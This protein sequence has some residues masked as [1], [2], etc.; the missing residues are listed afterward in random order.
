M[1]GV[2]ELPMNLFARIE[3]TIDA[4][5]IK[6]IQ[7]G[8]IKYVSSLHDDVVYYS[9][10]QCH[11]FYARESWNF[12]NKPNPRMDYVMLAGSTQIL[13]WV[14]KLDVTYGVVLAMEA[15]RLSRLHHKR[16]FQRQKAEDYLNNALA[17]L[18]TKELADFHRL[19][20]QR[21]NVHTSQV[22]YAN[23]VASN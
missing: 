5:L 13:T 3:P 2:H 17:M 8:I 12:F 14:P 4:Y 18:S 22:N 6:D 16:K 19:T 21:R 23:Q 9:D 11:K 20:A 1:E 7:S 15:H 10:V